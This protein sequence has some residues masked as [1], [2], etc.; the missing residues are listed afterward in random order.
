M[1]IIV[2]TSCLIIL[3]KIGKIGCLKK[4]FGEILIPQSVLNE[5]GERVPDFI[6]V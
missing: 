6:E 3:T 2:D 5:F 4:L 1:A